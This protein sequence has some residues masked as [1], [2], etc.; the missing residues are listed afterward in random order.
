M[1][2]DMHVSLDA[3]PE[4]GALVDRAKNVGLDG[5]VLAG[6]D[7]SFP[8]VD[9]LKTAAK[10]KGLSVFAATR[11]KTTNGLLLCLVPNPDQ[12]LAEGWA[13]RKDGFF[14]ATTVIDALK[15]RG[16][17][18]IALR[19]YDREVE[20]PMGDTIFTLVGLAACE[21]QNPKA[22]QSANNLALEAASNLELPCIGSSSART[23]EELGTAA[24]LFRK[25]VGTESELIDALT[26]GECWPI[27]FGTRIP[28][29]DRPSNDRRGGRGGDRDGG[30]GRRGGR[31][32]GGGGGGR[33]RGGDRDRGRGGD[34]GGP[35]GPGPGP[36]SGAIPDPMRSG[37]S[38]GEARGGGPR[39]GRRRGG[40]GRG[41]PVSEDAGNRRDPRENQELP[42]N[43]GNRVE[44]EREIADDIGNRLRP[45]ER[46]RFAPKEEEVEDPTDHRGNR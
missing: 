22:P 41:G 42:E 13:E 44:S 37:E 1:I 31:G 10:D 5:I 16:G 17:I 14:V 30:R 36:G 4:P 43:L 39:R 29:P 28:R 24:T 27:G 3:A 25:K 18:A 19:P 20:K 6:S 23:P 45:G 38:R 12:P 15:E 34:R 21:T 33:G 9:A 32:G 7:G 35:R 26:H 8:S 40:G 2:I 11:V 46:N